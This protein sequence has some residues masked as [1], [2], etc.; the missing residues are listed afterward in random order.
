MVRKL[1]YL[2]A[3]AL[4][5]T[6]PGLAS[7]D[8]VAVSLS[9]SFGNSGGGPIVILPNSGAGGTIA[10]P[11]SVSIAG[12]AGGFAVASS[13]ATSQSSG[14]AAGA[15]DNANLTP[16]AEIAYND[17]AN[18][19]ETTVSFA[20]SASTIAQVAAAASA[21]AITDLCA[22]GFTAT[23][24]G[25]TAFQMN[26]G[27]GFLIDNTVLTSTGAGFV[28]NGDKVQNVI[29]TVNFPGNITVSNGLTTVVCNGP[30]N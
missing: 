2:A 30:P 19:Y 24:S 1:S 11:T 13:V 15:T 21:Q 23:Q 25:S 16:L 10:A 29:V 28:S 22:A 4:V 12:A 9:A 6:V 8:G 5:A 27:A 17:G 14:A 3:I 7:A 26:D 20:P 18:A